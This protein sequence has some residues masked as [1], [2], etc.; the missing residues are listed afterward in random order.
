MPSITLTSEEFQALPD[1]AQAAI[2]SALGWNVSGPTDVRDAPDVTVPPL[3]TVNVCLETTK[4]AAAIVDRPDPRPNPI[5]MGTRSQKFQ[6]LL[7]HLSIGDVVTIPNRKTMLEEDLVVYDHNRYKCLY[8]RRT[9]RVFYNESMCLKN[10]LN[11]LNPK[12]GGFYMTVASGIY[13]GKT[14]SMITPVA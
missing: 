9:N 1:S 6:D 5:I 11:T 13:K 4:P 3:P 14:L 2:L 10:F 8:H 7:K 12:T